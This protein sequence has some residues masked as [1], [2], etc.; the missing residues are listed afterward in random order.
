[1]T[2]NKLIEKASINKK[3]SKTT[4]S[5]KLDEQKQQGCNLEVERFQL[6]ILE[7]N[8]AEMK[9]TKQQMKTVVESQI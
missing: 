3:I 9:A 5:E 7:I 1:M 4:R 2:R 6:N 8:G